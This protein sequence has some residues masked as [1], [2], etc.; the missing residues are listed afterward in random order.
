[1]K[2]P[3]LAVFAFACTISVAA[4]ADDKKTDAPKAK[5]RE[6]TATLADRL[7]VKKDFKVELL[8]S[9][10]KDKQGSW[11]NMCTD[12][13][14]RLIV[15][16][17]YGG[18]FRVTPP[19]IGGKADET[20]VERLPIDLGEAQ[21]LLWAFD[22]LYVVVNKGAKY[23]SGLYRV[24][25]KDGETFEKVELL[26]KLSDG[27][28]HGPH[29]VLLHPDGKRLVV[30]CGNN[31]Q[32]TE[33]SSSRVPKHWGEDHLLPRM[34]D[35]R[36]FMKGVLG[37][38]GKI[39]N[40]DP[41]GKEW[42]LFSVGYRNPYD[43]A[44]NRHG[45]LFTYDA[46]M[47]WDMNTP[48]YR[49]TRVCLATSGSE[50]GWRNGAGKW[51]AYYPDSLP[52]ILDIGPGSPTGVCFGYGA[53]FPAKYQEAFFICDWSYGK[54]YA[55]HLTGSGSA[56]KAEAE[57]FV[58][59]TPLQLTDVVVNPTDGAMYF[60]I[61]GRKTTSGLYRV[62]YVGNEPTVPTEGGAAPPLAALRGEL[63]RF[64]KS[65]LKAVEAAWP[66]LGHSD[67]F[68]RFAARVALEHQ[69]AKLWS[70][71]ALAETEPARALGALLALVRVTS[72]DPDHPPKGYKYD[73]DLKNRIL[74]KLFSIDW[75]KLTDEQRLDL[76]RIYAILFNRM[77]KPDTQRRAVLINDLFPEY[78]SKN[79]L[80][81]AELC[82]LFVYLETPG[83]AVTTLKLLAGAPTQEEQMEYAKSLRVLKKGWNMP[84]RKEYFSWFLKAANFK[85]GNSL[86][87]FMKN[88]KD[89]AIATLTDAE[90]KELQP[91]LDAAPV[92]QSPFQ[93]KPRPFVKKYKTVD[94]VP[95]LETGLVKRDFDRGRKLFGETSC[96][97]CHR[98]DNEGGAMGPDL[99][100]AAG[101]FSAR[102]LL[103]SIVEPSKVIS[104]QYAAVDVELFDGKHYSGRIINA[105]ND[106]IML[107]TNMLDPNAITTI[108]RRKIE[109]LETSKV[110]PMPEGLI[111]TLKEDEILDLMAYLLSRGDR[112]HAMF[113]K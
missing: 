78:P 56:Y 8:Y 101:R 88:I 84:Q 111:D 31:T 39:Y 63:E 38:G 55:V 110:S 65:D 94:V 72:K 113:K 74:D 52:G 89:D 5:L 36:G 112:N 58:T 32:M 69:D 71:K 23:Q 81:N 15:S 100:G 28:E 49:P 90:K 80:I 96:F 106:N 93:A 18:L 105:N 79:R 57:E 25:S 68:I 87:G 50:F 70:D 30:L 27:G 47:E 26:R 24:R 2:T 46:D 102:D 104:D 19:A 54:L 73:K 60:A 3:F 43:M 97:S 33:I 82:Q 42:E 99:T 29:A 75:S 13:K 17:Q 40:V 41:D 66:H 7:V 11:V 85:G 107:N 95:L 1:M 34:P 45:D 86:G 16:D 22:S 67:R 61:G 12:P 6:P 103:E 53:K 77:E 91:I 10:P 35:G 83:V 59:G 62:T 76:L 9:V 14:G 64:H 48:W 51:P 4:R 108:D 44:F 109:K 92:V 20:K 21:G 37:P 98:Y